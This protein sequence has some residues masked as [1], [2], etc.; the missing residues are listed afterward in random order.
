M[1]LRLFAPALLWAPV[2][3]AHEGHGMTGSAHWHASDAL[4]Y[5]A[6]LVAVAGLLWWRSRK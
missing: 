4:G 5:I 3:H 2:A 1:K 6:V